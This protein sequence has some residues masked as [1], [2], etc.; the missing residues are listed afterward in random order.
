MLETMPKGKQEEIVEEVQVDYFQQMK[1]VLR[2]RGWCQFTLVDSQGR[3]CLA[4]AFNFVFYGSAKPSI[5]KVKDIHRAIRALERASGF[6]AVHFPDWND[7]RGR[8]VEE[9][10][11]LLDRASEAY[12]YLPAGIVQTTL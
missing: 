7:H 12:K 6:T 5:W 9:V 3:M 8:T 2:E 1:E 4:G 10:F 11:E